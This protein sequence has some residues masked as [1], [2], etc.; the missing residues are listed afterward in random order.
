M[1]L[2]GTDKDISTK[3]RSDQLSDNDLEKRLSIV[4]NRVRTVEK[5]VQELYWLINYLKGKIQ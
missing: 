4:E 2:S 3:A 5:Q 1:S